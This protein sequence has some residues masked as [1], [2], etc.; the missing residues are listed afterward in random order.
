MGEQVIY[1]AEVELVH[2]DSNGMLEASKTVADYDKQSNCLKLVDK[3]SKSVCYI[4]EPRYR[5]RTIGQK[6]TYGDVV[7]FHN[8]KTDL[9]IHI[10]EFEVIWDQD[11]KSVKDCKDFKNVVPSNID[12]RMPPNMFA[13]LYEVNC[14][15]AKSKFTLLPFRNFEA[16]LDTATIKGSQVIRLQHS[17]TSAFVSSD[18]QDFTNDGLAEVFLWNYKGKSNDIESTTTNSL[19]ELEIALDHES[20]NQG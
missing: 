18:D 12:F 8:V 5:Y 15:S 11:R 6:V 9:Y 19:F 13:P 10:S 1:G 20:Q 7:A 14:S 3:G 2:V 4:I 17:E 16:S